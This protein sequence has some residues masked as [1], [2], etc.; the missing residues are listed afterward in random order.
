MITARTSAFNRSP[1]AVVVDRGEPP[2]EGRD[3]DGRREEVG[4][5]EYRFGG[6]VVGSCDRRDEREAG[7]DRGDDEESSALAKESGKRD[8]GAAPMMVHN[9]SAG[10]GT[11]VASISRLT[12]AARAMAATTVVLTAAIAPAS[13]PLR[14]RPRVLVRVDCTLGS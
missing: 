6:G 5:D 3:D 11:A 4:P 1:S 13:A 10:I 14:T 9:A 2:A 8:A 7:G 12:S